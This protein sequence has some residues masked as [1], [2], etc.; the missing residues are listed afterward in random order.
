MSTLVELAPWFWRR[1][2]GRH[3]FF[4]YFCYYPPLPLEEVGSHLLVENPSKFP[5]QHL[6]QV[7]LD[8]EEKIF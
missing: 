6:C 1:F 3:N 4:Y 5:S 2:F 7:S 8:L